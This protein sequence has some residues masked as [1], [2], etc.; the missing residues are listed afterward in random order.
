MRGGGVG[1]YIRNHLEGRIVENLSPFINQIFESVTIQLTYPLTHK[2]L[3]LTSAYRSNGV[4][5]GLTQ[6]QQMEQFCE[7][8][9]DL[10]FQL[11]ASNKECYMFMD[12][13]INLLDLASSDSQNYLNLLFSAGFLQCIHKA[14]RIQNLSKSLIDHIHCNNIVNNIISGVIISDISDHFFT[15]VCRQAT[16]PRSSPPKFTVSRDFSLQNLNNFKLD[17]SSTNWNTVYDANDVDSAYDCFWSNYS[18]LFNLHFPLKRK[19]INKNFNPMN[20]FMSQGLLISRRTKNRLHT[21]AISEPTPANINRYK[22]FK[23]IYQRVIRAA[24]KRH[25]ADKLTENAGNPKKNMANIK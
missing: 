7:N 6:A 17:L 8:F 2:S 3:L 10:I 24:K 4:I 14:T 15:F 19:R 13:N 9:G 1:F 22:E 18:K 5:P 12:A 21:L 25:I 11:Q 20:K 16:G 23:T